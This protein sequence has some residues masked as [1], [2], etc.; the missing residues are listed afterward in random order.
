MP[1]FADL[2]IQKKGRLFVGEIADRDKG[3]E[4]GEE[5]KH[6]NRENRPRVQERPSDT[7]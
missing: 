3:K 7:H 1:R 2:C 4:R 6:V 5:K